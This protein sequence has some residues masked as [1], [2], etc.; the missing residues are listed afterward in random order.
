MASKRGG[1]SI[2][3]ARPLSD[4]DIRVSRCAIDE[5]PG[6][7]AETLV[8]LGRRGVA[9]FMG[10]AGPIAAL[11]PLPQKTA[12]ACDA[13]M[14]LQVWFTPVPQFSNPPDAQAGT[15]C[16][17]LT[18]RSSTMACQTDSTPV[19]AAPVPRLGPPGPT[20][21]VLQKRPPAMASAAKTPSFNPPGAQARPAHSPH[22]CASTDASNP[23]NR[24]CMASA[25]NEFMWVVPTLRVC[26]SPA[27]RSTRK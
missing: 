16:G 23:G 5:E 8:F 12:M 10:P 27:S 14:R 26:T 9:V 3:S 17:L 21:T 25:R 19:G 24:A 4:C 1:R 7:V 13:I 22:R 15:R 18:S 6:G 20:K 11:G 2:A